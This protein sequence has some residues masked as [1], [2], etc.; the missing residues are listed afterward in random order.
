[1]LS[2]AARNPRSQLH[3]D[4]AETTFQEWHLGHIN[5]NREV[6]GDHLQ[7]SVLVQRERDTSDGVLADWLVRWRRRL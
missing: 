6:G 3:R 7:D 5:Q 1:M 4:W 2:I